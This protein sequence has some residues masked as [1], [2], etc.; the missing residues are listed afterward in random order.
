MKKDPL[1]LRGNTIGMEMNLIRVGLKEQLDPSFTDG[2]F[3]DR[4]IRVVDRFNCTIL[5][6]LISI[7][8][9]GVKMV[10]LKHFASELNK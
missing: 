3:D 1:V 6:T 10:H 7:D 2:P 8:F 9:M 5:T 4:T